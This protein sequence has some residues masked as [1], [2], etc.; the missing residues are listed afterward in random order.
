MFYHEIKDQTADA[1]LVIY[2]LTIIINTY[3][4]NALHTNKTFYI[5]NI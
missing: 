2:K 4:R 3:T 5:D 1:Y